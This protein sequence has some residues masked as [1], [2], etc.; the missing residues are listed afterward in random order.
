VRPAGGHDGNH[1]R[2]LGGVAIPAH[3]HADRIAVSVECGSDEHDPQPV[4]TLLS[5]LGVPLAT[6]RL[7]WA[8]NFRLVDRLAGAAKRF[9]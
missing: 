1:V 4:L 8:A 5:V 2:Q 3:N 7:D 9:A 6:V